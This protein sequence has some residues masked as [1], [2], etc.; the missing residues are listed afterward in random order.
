MINNRLICG[1]AAAALLLLP[2]CPGSTPDSSGDT[3]PA[4]TD[5][6]SFVIT[7]DTIRLNAPATS[8]SGFIPTSPG[9]APK[10]GTDI[11]GLDTATY[12]TVMAKLNDGST[13]KVGNVKWTSSNPSLVSIDEAGLARALQPGTF[14]TVTITAAHNEKVDLKADAVVTLVNDGHAAVEIE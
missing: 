10:G 3:G 7:P 4:P 1:L 6:A 12:F 5:I 2:G 8:E 13:R 14:G 9:G 11:A